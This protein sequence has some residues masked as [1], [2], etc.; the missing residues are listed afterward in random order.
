VS[1][2]ITDKL[3]ID[4]T[5]IILHYFIRTFWLLFHQQD[6]FMAKKPFQGCLLLMTY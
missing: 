5:K 6:I 4:T 1:E 3:Q 2:N